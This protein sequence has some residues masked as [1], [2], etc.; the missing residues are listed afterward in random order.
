MDNSAFIRATSGRHA[1]PDRLRIMTRF[2]PFCFGAALLLIPGPIASV[3]AQNDPIVTSDTVEYC[4]VLMSR[5]T[6]LSRTAAMPP[7]MAAAML[8]E[9]GERMCVHG[10]TRGGIMRLRRALAIMRHGE[11]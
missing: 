8:S 9:E 11:N 10:Q 4:G 7:P 1:N 5:I 6:G 2:S 3:R